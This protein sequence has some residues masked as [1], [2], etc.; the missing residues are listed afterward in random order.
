MNRYEFLKSMGFKGAALMAVMTACVSEDDKFIDAAIIDPNK[1]TTANGTS[2]KITTDELKALKNP[3]LTLS[4]ADASNANLL[5]IGG[6]VRKSRIVVA[7]VAKDSFAAVTQLCTHEPK[8]DV[9]FNQNEFYCTAHGAR[10]TIQ[11]KG[12]N[13]TGR[14]GIQ[15]YKVYTDGATIVVTA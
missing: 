6:Y 15:A 1:K 5:K 13:D 9:I 11:G 8:T 12:L 2:I 7:Q 10:F 14:K 3:L 4:L